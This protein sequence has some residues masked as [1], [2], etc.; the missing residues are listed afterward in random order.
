MPLDEDR[1]RLQASLQHLSHEEQALITQAVMLA[2]RVHEGQK[3]SDGS[4]YMLHVLAVATIL[5][6]WRADA[7]T[8][9]AGLLH[10]TLED[11][12]LTLGEIKVVFGRNVTAL[13]EGVTKFTQADFEEEPS[14]D[15]KIET[16][17]KLFEVMRRDIRVVIIKLADRLHNVRTLDT[18]PEE[19]RVRFAKETITIYYKLAYHLGMNA[20]RR[21]FSEHCM[22]YLYPEE[23][24]K[25]R[26]LRKEALA[27]GQDI[28]RCMEQEVRARDEEG[29]L[30]TLTLDDRSFSSMKREQEEEGRIKQGFVI[31]AIASDGAACY[32]L[33]RLLHSL[34]R[35][36]SS[37]FHDYIAAPTESAYQTIRTAVLGP[38]NEFVPLR[39]RTEEMQE[40]ERF[41][42]LLR[43]FG[44]GRQ[45]PGFSW[46]LRSEDIDRATRE[47]SE[48]F[49]EALQSDIFQ[50]TVSVIVD[51]KD[52]PLSRKATV[53]DALYARHGGVAHRT[54]GVRVNGAAAALSDALSEDAVIQGTLDKV[55][56][57]SFEWFSSIETAYARQ[58]IVEALKE[59][60]RSEKLA[61]GQRLLQKELDRYRKRVLAD[62]SR[63]HL[64]EVATYFHR[65][66]FEE[67]LILIGEGV[68]QARDVVFALH[69]EH[70][71]VF[72]FPRKK[73]LTQHFRIH[74][75]GTQEKT[76]D[77]LPKLS[78]LARL[79]EISIGKTD[80]RTHERSKTFSLSLSGTAP[81]RLH[82]GDFLAILER[83]SWIS[84][85]RVLLS[86]WQILFLLSVITVAFGAILLEV[87]FL[88]SSAALP[89]IPPFI[90]T[91]LPLL[92]ILGV[93]YLL[94]RTLQHYI[95]R[96]RT[97]RWYIGAGFLMNLIGLTLF[98]FRGNT[99]GETTPT[100]TLVAVFL[101]SMFA[102]GYQFFKS[103]A[104]FTHIDWRNLHPLTAEQWR[105]RWKQ[106]FFGYSIRL[107]AVTIWGFQP[108]LLK[109]TPAHNVHPFVQ[110]YIMSFGALL[111]TTL[112]FLLQKGISPRRL[113]T[114]RAPWNSYLLGI[115]IGEAIF[116]YFISAS[117]LYTTSTNFALLSNFSP[118]VALL[119][120]ALFWRHSIPYLR[121]PKHMLW[122]FLIFGM[123]STG[124]SLIIYRSAQLTSAQT[125][126]GDLLA[127][128]AMVADVLVITSQIRYIKLVPTASSPSI[129]AYMFGLP[130]LVLTPFIL[131][132][133][134]TGSEI[135]ASLLLTPVLFSL[136]IGVMLAIG[137]VC[138]FEAFRR[139]DGFIA[140]LMF[141]LSIL[142][143]FIAE[144]FFLK[145]IIPT[146]TLIIGGTIII[147][148]TIL[149]EYVNSQCE[150]RGL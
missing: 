1:Q 51:G 30:V 118:V 9:I 149:A 38:G 60:D 66:E 131:Y 80:L 28:L 94:L 56:H 113:S 89:G 41:G 13:V 135:F 77:I 4:P 16:L 23:V 91:L 45:I 119:V 74:M 134:V 57:V 141:N 96:L 15:R 101:L 78:A 105:A 24:Q 68:I 93:N 25:M 35:P 63:T 84:H 64:K 112:L 127:L 31:I 100:L 6:E 72:S 26:L 12:S 67:V 39:I 102:L 99:L 137:M 133:Y 139:I 70:R 107:C 65:E 73:A 147:G 20:V 117:L 110:M 47:S 5:G 106:K 90:R 129:N 52:I 128:S 130:T 85:I 95:V 140:F 42:I 62:V 136:G 46:L 125:T 120:A 97:D 92:P 122:I 79:S 121:D 76:Q 103:E 98:I 29:A 124:G 2:M 138:N 87:L 71:K 19:R 69:P 109:Y 144:A 27:K 75:S 115:V 55:S 142:L 7:E 104:L 37:E 33:L 146:W 48:A 18:L 111:T 34:Y 11:T 116:L 8:I 10:D 50:E 58:L 82:F 21:E 36:V 53:L 86:T 88:P 81:D 32:T 61:L 143:N 145:T 49:W 150:R 148:S 3:R 22:P 59:R 14:L 43:C 54:L 114:L 108:L 44:R 17:R 126:L 83:Q 40:Q 123:G 132:L